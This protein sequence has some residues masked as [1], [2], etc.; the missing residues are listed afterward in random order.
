MCLSFAPSCITEIVVTEIIRQRRASGVAR[1][2]RQ[3]APGTCRA[4]SALP[5]RKRQRQLR[6]RGGLAGDEDQ[7]EA[8]TL[9]RAA[10]ICQLVAR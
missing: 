7:F 5:L 4:R 8:G 9:W 3:Y 2:S 1:S 6:G 10:D